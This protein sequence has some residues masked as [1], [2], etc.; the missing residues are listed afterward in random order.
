MCF[1]EFQMVISISCSFNQPLLNAHYK[2]NTQIFDGIRW[3]KDGKKDK[4]MKNHLSI[5]WQLKD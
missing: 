5:L 3:I 4:R 1:L 2:Q